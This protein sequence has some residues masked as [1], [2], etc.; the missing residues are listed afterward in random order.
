MAQFIG[1]LFCRTVPGDFIER[2]LHLRVNGYP[3]TPA[4]V[5]LERCHVSGTEYSQVYGLPE[6]V[7]YFTGPF[8]LS[9]TAYR[10]YR[11]IL[12]ECPDT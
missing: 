5:T 12:T 8:S 3:L 1:S 7:F 10:V 11:S 9:K 2:V 6:P 4:S